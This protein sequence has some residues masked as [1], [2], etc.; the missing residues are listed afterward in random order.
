VSESE[1]AAGSNG[2]H[3]AGVALLLIA[4]AGAHAQAPVKATPLLAKPLA[5]FEGK[6][7]VML[8]VDYAPG[9]ASE[10]HRHDANTFVYVLE[11]SVVMQVEGGRPVT[12]TAGQTFYESPADVHTVSRNASE[13]QPA[14][15][16][17]F[18]VK[19]E[20]APSTLP[21]EARGG[22]P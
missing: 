19:D 16:L 12:L 2:Y 15:I 5:G 7:G 3:L 11:G 6:E 13:T 17:V 14:R 8:T 20:G 22:I 4:A 9:A 18:F 1:R 10:A 21:V